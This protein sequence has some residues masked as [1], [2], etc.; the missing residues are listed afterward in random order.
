[1]RSLTRA[2]QPYEFYES[3]SD[4]G[5]TLLERHGVSDDQLPVVIDGEDTYENATLVMLAEAWNA[6]APPA[7]SHYDLAIIGAGPAGLAAA[8][9]GASDGLSTIVFERDIPGGQAGHTSMIENFFGFPGGIEGSVA[10][11]TTARGG[12]SRLAP[13]ARRS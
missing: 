12:A 7:R 8:V 1:V 10:A 4:E 2:A 11:S 9:Y 3:E 5:R 13:G 6:L